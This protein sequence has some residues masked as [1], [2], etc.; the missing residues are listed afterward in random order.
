MIYNQLPSQNNN[1]YSEIKSPRSD[2]NRVLTAA[3]IN[4]QFRSLLLKNPGKAISRGYAGE[5]FK[6][7]SEEQ[8]KLASIKAT[9]LAEFAWKVND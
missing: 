8:H 4:T 1:V 7:G 3:V 6:L 9:N 5:Q 2:I